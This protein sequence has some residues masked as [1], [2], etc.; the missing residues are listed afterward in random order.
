MAQRI[1]VQCK[2][3]HVSFV[4]IYNE[5]IRD[6]L[7]SGSSEYLDLVGSFMLLRGLP[8]VVLSV[9]THRKGLLLRESRRWKPKMQIML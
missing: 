9:K 7:T 4:E 3:V 8:N 2:Q 6:L 1:I 5:N